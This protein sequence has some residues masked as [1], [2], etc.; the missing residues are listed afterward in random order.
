MTPAVTTATGSS[1]RCLI[2][3]DEPQLRALLRRLLEADGF[4]CDEASAGDDA[5]ARLRVQPVPLVL[6]DFHMPRMNGGQLLR[7]VVT[8]WPDTAVIM[9]TSE[10]DVEL[11]VRSLDAGAM[12]Y[13]TKPFCIDEVRARVN[14]ALEKRRLLIE[15]RAYRTELEERVA[16]QSRKYEELFLAS[17]QSLADALEVKD[18][19]TWGHSTRVS[20]YAVGIARELGVAPTLLEQLELGSRLHDIGKIG[21]REDVLNKDGALTD[22]EY[23]HVM[24]H[25]VIGWRLLAPLLRDMPHAL[26]VVRSHHERFDGRG[27]PDEMRGHEIPLEARITAVADSFDAMTSGR[28]YRPGMNVEDAVAELRRCAGLQFDPAVVAAFE[29]ALEAHAFPRPDWSVQ[30]PT[31]LAIVA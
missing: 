25:P 10:S 26:A 14:Q 30:R 16:M 31:R 2:V 28:V 11:A 27:T 6:T 9:I 20:R 5:I 22:E 1:R 13:L 15:N 3:D 24:E 18:A 17:L 8:H 4:A 23:A 21:V 7:E 12:D 29:R 19:Y